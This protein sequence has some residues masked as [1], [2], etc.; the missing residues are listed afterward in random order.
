MVLLKDLIMKENGLEAIK[1][2]HRM[3]LL[4]ASINK[5]SNLDH[6]LLN[7]VWC[8][9]FFNIIIIIIIILLGDYLISR[10]F[11]CMDLFKIKIL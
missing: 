3:W 8:T 10:L 4:K 7:K 5:S 9:V 1:D 6:K 11:E 2:Y